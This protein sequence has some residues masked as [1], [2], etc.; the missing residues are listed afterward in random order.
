MPG[1]EEQ[2]TKK[3]T[4]TI[5]SFEDLFEERI[6]SIAREVIIVSYDPVK[7]KQASVYHP[8]SHSLSPSRSA[9]LGL[10]LRKYLA[11]Y[12]YSEYFSGK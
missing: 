2:S 11:F 3:A 8:G 1:S 4:L 12:A 7:G 6:A 10:L 9:H 5:E